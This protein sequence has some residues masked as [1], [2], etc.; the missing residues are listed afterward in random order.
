MRSVLPLRVIDPQGINRGSILAE[1]AETDPKRRRGLSGRMTLPPGTGMIF[2]F[3]RDENLS[4]S[5]EAMRFPLDLVWLDA[6][7]NVLGV[8]PG[9]RPGTPRVAPPKPYRAALEVGAGTAKGL[10]PGWRVIP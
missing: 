9:A 7:G 3:D 8:V 5:M 10:G 4:F 2:L 6:G 1:V